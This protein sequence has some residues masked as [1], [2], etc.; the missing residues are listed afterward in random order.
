MPGEFHPFALILQLLECRLVKCILSDFGISE[1]FL[2]L[3]WVPV[4]YSTKNE[5]RKRKK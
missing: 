4:P 2:G 3:H 1:M 5:G